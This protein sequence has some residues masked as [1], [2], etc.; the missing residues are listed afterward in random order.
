M[1]NPGSSLV[2]A[3]QELVVDIHAQDITLEVG[4]LEKRGK[5]DT[6]NSRRHGKVGFGDKTGLVQ[7]GFHEKKEIVLHSMIRAPEGRPE[8]DRIALFFVAAIANTLRD[9]DAVL[10]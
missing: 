8:D 9:L 3:L 7:A 5:R 6:G 4:V 10:V 2:L 1:Q